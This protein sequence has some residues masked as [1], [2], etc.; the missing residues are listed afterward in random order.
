MWINNISEIMYWKCIIDDK[1]KYR[2]NITEDYWI[3]LYCY[4]IQD[5]PEMYNRITNNEYLYRYCRYVKDRPELS[6][7]IT[8]D[9]YKD[10]YKNTFIKRKSKCG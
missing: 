6:N 3:Y 2:I 5:R 8:G 4:L 9:L 10:L 1:E 7:K